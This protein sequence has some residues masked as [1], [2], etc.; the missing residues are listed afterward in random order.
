MNRKI[1]P[2]QHEAIIKMY[3]EDKKPTTEICK[4]FNVKAGAITRVL[5]INNIEIQ[6]YR[7]RKYYFDLDY[8][9]QIDTEDKAYFLGL[10]YADG[11]VR[12]TR[13]G[14]VVLQLQ[15]KDTE[16]LESMRGA[17]GYTG[18]FKIIQKR[19]PHH[20]N[21]IRLELQSHKMAMD[22]TKWGC[23]NKK[24]LTLKFP[25]FLSG[26]LLRHFIRGYFD[27]DGG[28]TVPT[29]EFKILSSFTSS[30]FF[31]N[32]LKE[33]LTNIFGFNFYIQSYKYSPAKSLRLGGTRQNIIFLDWLYK[34]CSVKM[35]RKY[36]KFINFINKYKARGSARVKSKYH[37]E[38]NTILLNY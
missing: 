9:S 7:N 30:P 32:T 22:L 11:Y 5:K 4:I 16:T 37:E 13:G 38:I 19:K 35:E 8:F 1:Y 6:E 36:N 28:I 23:F 26:E 20:Q 18:D 21:K 2:N 12:T 14:I 34:N 33:V 31:I 27:G 25:D 3:V 24:S 10:L 17:V 29:K 15:E